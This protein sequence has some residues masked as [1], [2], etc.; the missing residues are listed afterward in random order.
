MTIQKYA[1]TQTQQYPS[2][3]SYDNPDG[4]IPRSDNPDT[5]PYPVSSRSANP[6]GPIPQHDNPDAVHAGRPH[7]SEHPA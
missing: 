3:S 2:S 4:L 1:N 5:V 7:Y 6:V